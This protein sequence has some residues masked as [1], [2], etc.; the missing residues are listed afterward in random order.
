MNALEDQEVDAIVESGMGLVW[1]P[2]NFMYYGIAQSARSRFPELARRGTPIAFGTDVAKAWAFGELGF[3]AYLLSREWGDYLPSD[4]LLEMFTLGG[5]HA[6][7]ASNELGSLEAGKRADIVIRTNDLPDAQPNVDV[8]RQLMLVSRTKSIDTV[9]CNGEVVVKHG[10]LTRLD[11]SAVYA[12]GQASARR[13]ADRAGIRLSP[14][15][16]A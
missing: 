3:I 6:M 2:G 15:N 10:H 9:I 13:M 12:L 14:A 1:H 7:G 4:A 11:E 8:V 16:A 5:A